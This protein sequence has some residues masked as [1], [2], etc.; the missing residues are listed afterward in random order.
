MLSFT[1]YRTYYVSIT[2]L[3]YN[4]YNAVNKDTVI[5]VNNDTLNSIAAIMLTCTVKSI[6]DVTWQ[7]DAI[8]TVR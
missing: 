1:T 2:S 4:F 7:T 6:T 8:V 3:N 5:C